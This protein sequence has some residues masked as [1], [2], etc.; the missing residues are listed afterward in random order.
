MIKTMQ[1]KYLITLLTALFLASCGGG[2]SD[3][4]G[5]STQ[6]TNTP[7]GPYDATSYVPQEI[8]V[9]DYE[10]IGR[11]TLGL[12]FVSSI[13]GV[14]YGYEVY[15][16]PEYD[17]E[18][19][20]SFPVLY[21]T[22]AQYDLTFHAKMLDFTIDTPVIMVGIDEGPAGRRGTDYILPGARTYFQFFTEEFIPMIENDYRILPEDRTFMGASAGGSISL[23]MLFMDYEVPGIFKNHF[24]FDPFATNT[25]D[26]IID[27][28]V[29]SGLP[30]NK[31]LM[32]SSASGGFQNNVQPFV[33]QLQSRAIE[34]LV[35][36]E[37]TY[38][39]GHTDATW[40]S[41]FTALSLVYE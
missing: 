1:Y 13:T 40:A 16:P 21:A 19:T 9:N 32:V 27:E 20:R 22:D 35:I 24:A 39:V 10:F 28:R 29:T 12:S 18:P 6:Q 31:T 15:L 8:L 14:T 11:R 36:Q 2:S 37:R 34:G 17:L 23:V 38:D 4:D 26:D 7:R 30:F 33:A 41:L 3:S 5:G 25:L